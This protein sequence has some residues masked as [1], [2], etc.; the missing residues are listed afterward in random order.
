[1]SLEQSCTSR[2]AENFRLKWQ[3]RSKRCTA[4]KTLQRSEFICQ[5][6]RYPWRIHGTND[7]FTY[8]N[9]IKVNH[10]WICK[11]TVRHRHVW[12]ECS[13]LFSDISSERTRNYK[14]CE[15]TTSCRSKPFSTAEVPVNRLFCQKNRQLIQNRLINSLIS[16]ASKI[17]QPPKKK[18][19]SIDPY[20]SC[21]QCFFHR[22][23]SVSTSMSKNRGR[24]RSE[25]SYSSWRSGSY[26][27]IE[28]CVEERA[29]W[30]FVVYSCV[31]QEVPCKSKV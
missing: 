25:E 20:L 10:P 30:P 27:S 28:F 8:M 31:Y 23:W 2:W 16:I 18:P 29:E 9:T 4:T 7:I 15:M 5:S 6:I 26:D 1:M 11:Y 14:W 12:H 19:N 21:F 3:L 17:L 13:H 22:S 24:S